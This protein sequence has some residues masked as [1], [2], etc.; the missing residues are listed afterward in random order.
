MGLNTWL[1][2]RA[3]RCPHVFI[4][5]APGAW[6]QRAALERRALRWGW[7]LCDSPG[8]ADVLAICGALGPELTVAI[9]R[10]WDQLPGPRA[11]LRL[12]GT[13]IDDAEIDAALERAQIYLADTTVQRSDARER[14]PPAIPSVKRQNIR[15]QGYGHHEHHQH[16]HQ[17]HGQMAPS[18]ISLAEGG[19]DRDGLEMDLLHI[20]LGPVLSHWPASLVVRCALQGDLIVEARAQVLDAG[21]ARWS[22]ARSPRIEAARECDRLT[23]LLSLAGWPYA[24]SRARRVRDLLLTTDGPAVQELDALNRMVTRSRI[25]GWSMRGVTDGHTAALTRA[26]AL[27]TGWAPPADTVTTL[28][29]LPDRIVGLE[30][31]AARLVVAGLDVLQPASVQREATDD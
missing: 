23:S 12:T 22:P 29:D 8:S 13:E 17:G 16:G 2:R 9:G 21:D 28:V 11:G 27:L 10:V 26:R 30:L 14:Q 1:A 24:A 25:F 19:P 20:R 3:A 15:E 31:A 5:E 6:R 7:H 18:G 4:A